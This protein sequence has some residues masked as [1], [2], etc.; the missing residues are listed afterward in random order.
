MMRVSTVLVGLAATLTPAAYV[1][2]CADP[3]GT[4]VSPF[5]DLD[6]AS[7]DGNGGDGALGPIRCSDV[8]ALV[9]PKPC[10]GDFGSGASAACPSGRAICA[11]GDCVSSCDGNPCA[12]GAHDGPLCDV[13]GFA[14]GDLARRGDARC[15]V[16]CGAGDSCPAGMFCDTGVGRTGGVCIRALAGGTLFN[17]QAAETMKFATCAEA[18]PVAC[19]SGKAFGVNETS[20]FQGWCTCGLPPG[21][22]CASDAECSDMRC[23]PDK[24]CGGRAGDVCTPLG[25]SDVAIMPERVCRTSCSRATCACEK[26]CAADSDCG[27][28][29]SGKICNER[30]TCVTGCRGSGGNGCAAPMFCTSTGPGVGICTDGL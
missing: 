30:K 1:T 20:D 19:A 16:A 21:S 18:A 8:P 29:T 2:A 7:G 27:S 26:E 4:G 11:A 25:S 23:N 6:A 17:L 13:V 5:L 28:P 10:N 12:T 22:P 9:S 3:V 14:G 15:G 24:R